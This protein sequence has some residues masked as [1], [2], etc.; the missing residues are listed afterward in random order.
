MNRKIPPDAFSHY[1]SLGPGRSYQAVAEHYGVSRRAVSN[2]ADRE[3][4]Q[5]RLADLER[6]ARDKVD[7]KAV[8]SLEE[9]NTRHLKVM[10]FIQ[11]KAIE[12]LKAMPIDS[13][14]DAV[15]AYGITLD[16]ERLIRGEPNERGE[17]SIEEITK[18]ELNAWLI[19]PDAQV[20]FA[21]EAEEGASDGGDRAQ[22]E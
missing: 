1:F 16:K 2:L 5:Q 3:G 20:T 21:A 10:R 14:M 18:R 8:E 6:K 15:R 12:A 19:K 4:W 9:M 13:A 22:A 17:L 7:E 11:G